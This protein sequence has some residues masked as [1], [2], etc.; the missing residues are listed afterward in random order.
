MRGHA[1]IAEMS[2][3]A[4]DQ[5]AVQFALE[6]MQPLD[7]AAAARVR[8][9]AHPDV[10]HVRLEGASV[11]IDQIRKVIAEASQKPY[12]GGRRV[13]CIHN[14]GSM[15]QQAQNAL[16]KSLEEPLDCNTY[17][18][19]CSSVAPLLPTVRNRFF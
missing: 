1:F 11:K 6:H 19:L 9:D 2:A 16:L 17:L 15:T 4:F 13:I 14:A 5:Y 3:S 8:H 12:E 10:L 18:L 7:E